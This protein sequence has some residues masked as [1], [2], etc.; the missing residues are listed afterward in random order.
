M[1][2]LI[3]RGTAQFIVATHSPVLLPFPDANIVSFD[4]GP[5]RS[6]TLEETSHYRIT[7]GI[8]RRPSCIG[9]DC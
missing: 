4:Q 6:V 3:A 1:A 9:G 5:L 2:D 7:R 8:L